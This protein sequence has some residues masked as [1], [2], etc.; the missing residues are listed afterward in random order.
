MNNALSWNKYTGQGIVVKA[1]NLGEYVTTLTEK[2][3]LGFEYESLNYIEGNG[4]FDVDGQS[5]SEEHKSICIKYI[6]NVVV[7]V[8]WEK[9]IRKQEPLTYLNS[10]A[11]LSDKFTEIV[12]I[13]KEITVEEFEAKYHDIYVKR[14]EARALINSIDAE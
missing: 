8:E 13:Y 1:T 10:T 3:E 2:P 5:M 14:K 7:P 9:N 11:W 4:A 6:T 12:T